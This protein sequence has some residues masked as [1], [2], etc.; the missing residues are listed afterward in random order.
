TVIKPWCH[1][2]LDEAKMSELKR[3]V[4]YEAWKRE[5]AKNRRPV[6]NVLSERPCIER[7]GMFQIKGTANGIKDALRYP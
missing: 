6:K 5:F 2:I 3:L 7:L 1:L 4:F